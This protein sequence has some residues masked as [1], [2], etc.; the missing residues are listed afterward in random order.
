[1]LA[2]LALTSGALLRAS[3]GLLARPGA[4][5]QRACLSMAANPTAKFKTSKGEFTAELY[6]DKM[7]VTSSNFVDLAKSG[8]YDGLTFHRVIKNFMCQVRD[9]RIARVT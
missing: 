9:G 8:Y 3:P 5:R 6:M 4:L 2:T 1:M 7:P